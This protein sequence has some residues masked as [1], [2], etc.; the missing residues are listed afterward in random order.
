M[1]ERLKVS[2][3]KIYKENTGRNKM[4]AKGC[5]EAYLE[6][7]KQFKKGQTMANQW[8]GLCKGFHG[9]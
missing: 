9:T 4:D 7:L 3:V 5:W 1:L 8:I 2:L 6:K